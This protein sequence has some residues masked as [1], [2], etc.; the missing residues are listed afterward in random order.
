MC[1]G[2]D[3]WNAAQSHQADVNPSK[4]EQTDTD[5]KVSPPLWRTIAFK[6]RV[7]REGQEE[8]QNANS[9]PQHEARDKQ[10]RWTEST[11][12]MNFPP[13]LSWLV[14]LGSTELLPVAFTDRRRIYRGTRSLTKIKSWKVTQNPPP[15]VSPLNW[16]GLTSAT[17]Y[18]D[19]IALILITN[20]QL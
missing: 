10:T 2:S 8:P 6:I 14:S 20:S 5:A 18:R 15:L 12:A 16:N 19:T 7:C 9:K 17:E 1:R 4:E 11:E 13:K 3:I